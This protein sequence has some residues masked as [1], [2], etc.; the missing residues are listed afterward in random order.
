MLV[1]DFFLKSMLKSMLKSPGII[2]SSYR[3]VSIVSFL[4]DIY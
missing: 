3:Y 4:I 2:Y 1:S